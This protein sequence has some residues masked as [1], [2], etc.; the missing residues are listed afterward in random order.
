MEFTVWIITSQ[1]SCKVVDTLLILS[2]P[3]DNLIQPSQLYKVVTICGYNWSFISFLHLEFLA[4]NVQFTFMTLWHMSF[5]I[6][7]SSRIKHLHSTQLAELAAILDSFLLAQ[8][9]PLALLQSGKLVGAWVSSHEVV[10]KSYVFTNNSHM[11]SIGSIFTSTYHTKRLN[12]WP[13][14]SASHVV[15]YRWLSTCQG[16]PKGASG[17]ESSEDHPST[18]GCLRSLRNKPQQNQPGQLSAPIPG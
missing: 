13:S 5:K 16:E 8:P 10:G 11:A 7:Q 2:Q 17:K 9:I 18:C 4:I 14:S 12:P 3:N 1:S 6:G 15:N